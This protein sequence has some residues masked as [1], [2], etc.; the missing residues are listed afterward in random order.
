[1]A[2]PQAINESYR[3]AIVSPLGVYKPQKMNELFLKYGK[4]GYEWFMILQSLGVK[5]P[6]ANSS[7]SHFEDRD[8]HQSFQVLAGVA[9]PGAGLVQEL[10]LDTNSVTA[11]TNTFYPQV[12]MG[13][14]YPNGA[15]GH[16]TTID[17][18]VPTAPVLSIYPRNVL[19]DLPA[20]ST[21]DYLVLIDNA[22]G[23]GTDQPASQFSGYDEITNYTQIFKKS[24]T[25]TGSELTTEPWFIKDSSGRSMKVISDKG[26][27]DMDYRMAHDMSYALMFSV[28]TTNTSITDTD[29]DGN[30]VPITTTHG[31]W[32]AAET[33]GTIHNYTPGAFSITDDFDEIARIQAEEYIFG[34]YSLFMA[35]LRLYQDVENSAVDFTKEAHDFTSV[36]SSLFGGDAGLALSVGFKTIKKSG[37]TYL[38]K[39]LYALSDK[40]TLGASGYDYDKKGI[41]FPLNELKDKKNGEMISSIGM[42]YKEYNGISRMMKYWYEGSEGLVTPT[43]GWDNKR[44]NCRSEIGAQWMGANRFVVIEP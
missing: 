21:D 9:A 7:F 22:H 31:F 27:L 24:M 8:I 16:I 26:L 34:G 3:T 29:F 12:N 19:V 17:V 5:K 14:M 23:E 40:N 13:V 10:T 11:V 38:V 15:I 41:L 42:R 30:S 44:T 37:I 20:V 32:P 36:S 4:Q 33:Y 35:G 43:D 25:S 6:V 28:P 39:P 18:S 2:S 1:M